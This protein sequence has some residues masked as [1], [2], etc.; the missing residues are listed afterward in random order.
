MHL[1]YNNKKDI[2]SQTM[3]IITE[4]IMFLIFVKIYGM[5]YNYWLQKDFLA[6][7]NSN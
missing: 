6:R 7:R 4:I 5:L 3:K 2:Q 1:Y